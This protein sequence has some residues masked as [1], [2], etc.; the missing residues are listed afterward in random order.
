[1]SVVAHELEIG[2]ASP[3]FSLP[4]GSLSGVGLCPLRFNHR[5][6]GALYGATIAV[7]VND[8]VVLERPVAALP[9]IA[10][11]GD[12]TRSLHLP[13]GART[14]LVVHLWN[15]DADPVPCRLSLAY[16]RPV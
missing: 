1:M 2:P 8:V 6:L 5:T 3:P 4:P 11:R 7:L 14:E 16:D 10:A 13:E 12:L 9:H 15:E